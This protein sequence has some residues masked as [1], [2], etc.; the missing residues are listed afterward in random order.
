MYVLEWMVHMY[1]Y[2]ILIKNNIH[3]YYHVYTC[4]FPLVLFCNGCIYIHV[5]L[6]YS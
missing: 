2:C 3:N 6:S 1:V 5:L 4:S